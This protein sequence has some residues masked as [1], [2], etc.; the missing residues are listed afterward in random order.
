VLA[1]VAQACRD[2]VRLAFGY[3]GAPPPDRG[4]AEALAERYVEPY[5]VIALGRRWYLVAYD[6]D[7]SDWRTFRLDRMVDPRPARTPF[8]P[9]PLPADDLVEYVR[10]RIRAL[11]LVHR[12]VAD[13]GLS[14]EQVRRRLG[15]W[16]TVE[17]IPDGCRISFD[18][19]RLDW[20]LVVLAGLD[21]PLQLVAP[22]DL[23]QVAG[24]I[25]RQ[26]VEAAGDA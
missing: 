16:V 15:S 26:L 9:R 25:G 1:F 12:V 8:S 5:R 7:R 10:Q 13:V 18:A 4:P 23:A 20:P 14:E 2:G 17:P 3:A 24:R 19:D 11:R 6:M 21:A 22:D